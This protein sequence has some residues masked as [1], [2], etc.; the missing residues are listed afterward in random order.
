MAFDHRFMKELRRHPEDRSQDTSRVRARPCRAALELADRGRGE[1][2]LAGEL[3]LAQPGQF[4][5]GPQPGALERLR[6]HRSP[7]LTC[8]IL[9]STSWRNTDAAHAPGCVPYTDLTTRA[10]KPVRKCVS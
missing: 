10:W 4:A 3:R 1:P 6:A 8:L 7:C 5:G 2:A 9:V